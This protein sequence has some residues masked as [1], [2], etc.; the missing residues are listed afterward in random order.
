MSVVASKIGPPPRRFPRVRALT[1]GRPLELG[2]RSAAATHVVITHHTSALFSQFLTSG[3]QLYLHSSCPLPSSSTPPARHRAQMFSAPKVTYTPVQQPRG[4]PRS[5][6]PFMDHTT[7]PHPA[8]AAREAAARLVADGPRREH[9]GAPEPEL[10]PPGDRVAPW[11]AGRSLPDR[12]LGAVRRRRGPGREVPEGGFVV[13]A[14]F[15]SDRPTRT[16]RP[17]RARW[18]RRHSH[19]EPAEAETTPRARRNFP[20]TRHHDVARIHR[21]VARRVGRRAP[22]DAA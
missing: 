22:R 18:L 15:F 8:Q 3:L 11:R 12:L 2:E 5:H 14:G 17:T 19:A 7:L 9:L 6:A 16:G 13:N 1:P 21:G 4:A 20:T 10:A